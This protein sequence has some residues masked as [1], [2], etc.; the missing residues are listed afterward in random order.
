V[1][2]EPGMFAAMEERSYRWL[3]GTTLANGSA[4]FAVMMVGGWLAFR[5]TRSALGPGLVSFLAY[6]PAFLGPA[7][8][9]LADRFDRRRLIRASAFLGGATSTAAALLAATGRLGL[10]G[11]LLLALAAG[12]A[13]AVEQPSRISLVADV[14]RPDRLLNAFSLLRIPMQGSEFVGPGLA[15]LLLV[16]G[17]P[18]PALALCAAFYGLAAL[19]VGRMEGGAGAAGGERQGGILASVR[20]GLAHVAAEPRIGALILFVG[21]HCAFTMAFMGVLPS[22][23]A[24]VLHGGSGDYGLLMT[25]VG[26]GSIAGPLALAALA[27]RTNEMR[28]LL[29]M[30]ALSGATLMLLG[31]GRTLPAAAVAAFGTGAT[32]APFMV[33]IYSLTQSLADEAMRGRVASF[34]F[35][36][37]G[38]V[39]GMFNLFLGLLAERVS[40]A[41]VMVGSGLV[42]VLATGVFLVRL[43]WMRWSASAPPPTRPTVAAGR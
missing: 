32:Q 16:R 13:V 11:V 12:V 27:R 20:D 1:R 39:M 24:S 37:T 43:P 14:V 6:A 30:A 15:S 33:L 22:F 31:A 42:F 23:A 3:W 10:G 19:Q 5:F 25:C 21:F 9:A 8:G 36:F 17:G 34:T 40:P 38:G 41:A 35:F 28:A 7:S 26:L 2:S 4:R 29:V 18:A